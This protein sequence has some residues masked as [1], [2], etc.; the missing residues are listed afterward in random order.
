MSHAWNKSMKDSPKH[1]P[2]LGLLWTSGFS[3]SNALVEGSMDATEEEA[4]MLL[5][6][7]LFLE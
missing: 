7:K 2:K 5:G 3:L 6:R 1:L 4:E